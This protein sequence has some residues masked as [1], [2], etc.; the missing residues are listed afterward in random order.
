MNK[1]LTKNDVEDFLRPKWLSG[2]GLDEEGMKLTISNAYQHFFERDRQHK[3]VLEFSET[4]QLL[5]LNKTRMG[6]LA[7][8]FGPDPQ[9]WIGEAIW[10]RSGDT[11][12]GKTVVI[13]GAVPTVTRATM[14]VPTVNGIPAIDEHE[15]PF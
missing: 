5:T 8:M 14:S 6:A 7:A 3:S 11:A 9:G 1:P 13:T 2:E 15:V 10:V 4:S 12:M